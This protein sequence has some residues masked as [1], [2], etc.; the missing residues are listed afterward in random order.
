L[1]LLACVGSFVAFPST[2]SAQGFSDDFSSPVL[3]PGWM[4]FPGQGNS[5]SLVERPGFLRYRLTPF[6]HD[7]GFINAFLPTV[8]HHSCC[9]H[10]SGLELHRMFGGDHWTFETRVEYFMPFAN[11]RRLGPRVYFGTGGPNTFYV[12]FERVRDVH[13]FNLI[14]IRLMH[15]HGATLNDQTTLEY[16]SLDLGGFGPAESTHY[17]RLDRAGGVLTAMHSFDGTSWTTAWSHDLGSQLDLLPQ[18]VVLPGLSWAVPAGS[19]IDYDY[20]R[21]TE[22]CP[23]GGEPL[24]QSPQR[25]RLRRRRHPRRQRRRGW[26]RRRRR[27]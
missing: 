18:R 3:Q 9:T 8:G 11:G 20:V 21:V 22:T 1:V 7:D 13:P 14:Q 5:F 23:T 24:R 16:F 17:F 2:A 26:R 19:Y 10:V 27:G 4:V 15:K 25:R 12:A 6:T